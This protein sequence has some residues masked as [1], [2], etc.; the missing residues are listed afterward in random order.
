[1]Q[2][3]IENK[4]TDTLKKDLSMSSNTKIIIVAVIILIIVLFA[5]FLK[6]KHHEQKNSIEIP[7]ETKEETKEEE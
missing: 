7:A 5:I 3:Q 2:T 4:I 1:M 6:S